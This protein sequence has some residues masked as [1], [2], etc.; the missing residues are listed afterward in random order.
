MFKEK[1]QRDDHLFRNGRVVDFLKGNFKIQLDDNDELVVARL[2]GKM[3][4]NKILL[5]LGDRVE[6]KFSVYDPS[7]NGIINR[8]L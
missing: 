1:A 4:L 5:L 2:S 7:T 6:V 3:R 8:R